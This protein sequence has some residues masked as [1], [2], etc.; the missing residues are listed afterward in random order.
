MVET[1]QENKIFKVKHKSW[2]G[3]GREHTYN[4]SFI[5]VIG[6]VAHCHTQQAAKVLVNMRGYRWLEAWEDEDTPEGKTTK[7]KRIRLA[8]RMAETLKA[9]GKGIKK[10]G[11]SIKKATG[12]KKSKSK[13]DKETS[14]PSD[15]KE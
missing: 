7:A 13:K 14:E 10:V 5:K 4:E 11:D 15:S 6:G 12:S 1:K 3:D 9:A 2:T 8:E